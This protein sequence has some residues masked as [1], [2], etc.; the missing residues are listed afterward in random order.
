MTTDRKIPE[1][2]GI[3]LD[4]N[5]RWA[6][7]KGLPT[8]E[9]H[10]EGA[11]R[12]HQAIYWIRDRGI[13]HLAVYAFSMENWHRS[14]KEVSYLLKLFGTMMD[15]LSVKLSKENI[16]VRFV[17][18]RGRFN[19]GIRGAMAR[20]EEMSAKNEALAL[21]VCLSYSGRSEIVAAAKAAAA[22]GSITE[23]TLAAHLW[24]FGMPDPD[25]IIRTGGER[26]FSGFLTWQSIYSELF[27]IDEYWSDFSE[28]ILDSILN[29]YKNRERRMGK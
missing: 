9:G 14:E 12:L 20:L 16:R 2:I 29:E 7:E 23:E 11:E 4:G 5:R 22:E 10:L 1:C 19:V 24:T 15:K 25:V 8:F 21:W 3:I 17:G 6:K 27:F 18:E 13:K 28:T 26:R